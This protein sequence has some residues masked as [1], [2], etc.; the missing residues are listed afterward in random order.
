[1]ALS[2]LPW[3]MGIHLAMQG[4]QVQSLVREIPHAAQ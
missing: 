4:I 3:W 1:M 2:G